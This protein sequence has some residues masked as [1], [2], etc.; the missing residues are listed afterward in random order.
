MLRS[1]ELKSNAGDILSN[2][3]RRSIYMDHQRDR[4]DCSSGTRR[5]TIEGKREGGVDTRQV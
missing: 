4:W 3:H 5:R 1:Y 2:L